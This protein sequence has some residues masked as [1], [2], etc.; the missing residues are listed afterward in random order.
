[1]TADAV[2]DMEKEESPSIAGG[3]ASCY[4]HFRN[5]SGSS[6]EN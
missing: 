6:S 3:I 5:Q 1:M 4:K 2:K